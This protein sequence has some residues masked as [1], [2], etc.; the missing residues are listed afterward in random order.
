MSTPI[1]WGGRLA[2]ADL[3]LGTK[4]QPAHGIGPIDPFGF[5]W[6]RLVSL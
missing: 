6:P 5:S 3:T 2:S 4:S 1:G